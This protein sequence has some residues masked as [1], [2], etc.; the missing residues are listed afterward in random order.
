MSDEARRMALSR[1]KRQHG[2][3]PKPSP[4]EMIEE[5]VPYFFVAEDQASQFGES[6]LEQ[7][8]DVVVYAKLHMFRP[9]ALKNIVAS[10]K[11]PLDIVRSKDGIFIICYEKDAGDIVKVLIEESL[12]GGNKE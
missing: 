7:G 1:A 4:P 2:E 8:K 10:G 6:N 3:A 11:T 12:K 9:E 5:E